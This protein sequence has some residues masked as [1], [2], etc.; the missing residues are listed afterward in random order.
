MAQIKE[1][2]NEG[3]KR[4]YEVTVPVDV[5]E[6]NFDAHLLELGKKVQLPGFRPGKIP[7]AILKKRYGADVRK[8]VLDQTMSDATQKVLND[9]NLRPAMQ[10]KIQLVSFAEGKDVEFKVE[11]EILPEFKLA[12]F[13]KI[14]IE[15]SVAD[16]DDKAVDEA[17]T[18]AAKAMREPVA[19]TEARAAALGDVLLINFDGTVGGVAQPG[20]KGENHSLELG[21][22]SF[23]DTFEDQLVGSKAGDKKVIKVTFPQNYHAENLSGKEAEFAV[24]VREIRG[25]KPVDMSDE[26]AKDMGFPSIEKLRE[27][28]RDDI[29]GNYGNI[30]RAIAKRALMD[31]LADAHNFEVPAGMVEAEFRTI[32][33]QVEAAQDRGEAPEEDKGKSDD[34]LKTEY[35]AIAE[36]RV[37]LG[38]LLA[39]VARLQKIDVTP[40]SMRNALMAEAR[41][42]PGQEKA[43]IDYYTNTKGALERLRAPLLEDAVIDYIL[44][45]AKVTDKKI[46]A[47][48]LLKLPEEE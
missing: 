17:I 15:R 35:R 48:E 44:T 30:S 31:K 20:M 12:D 2:R 6:K 3:L 29:A 25:H 33:L 1:I 23:I 18:R 7:V 43:V 4:E 32:W 27:R 11:I 21:S 16:V 46:S 42:Y 8:D 24:E 40:E 41:R 39:E 37:R 28:V 22:K 13:T 26:M 47:D 14:E 19:I 9:N 36:R 34:Q 5:V 10:P 38:L 45:Q